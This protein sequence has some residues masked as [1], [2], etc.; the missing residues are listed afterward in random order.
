MRVLDF[1]DRRAIIELTRVVTKEKAIQRLVQRLRMI[2]SIAAED[3]DELVRLVFERE[4]LGST[5][6]GS[7]VAIPHARFSGAE[8]FI[9]ALGRARVGIDFNS[10]DDLDVD[11]VFLLI[12]P[13][14]ATSDHLKALA[15]VAKLFRAEE[16]RLALAKAPNVNAMYDLIA[17]ADA[18]R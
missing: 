16:L 14:G 3:E 7:R 8:K 6:V 12:S 15:R 1:L 9:A 18:K 5:G 17:E 11:L 2:G 4:R 13:L 10:V